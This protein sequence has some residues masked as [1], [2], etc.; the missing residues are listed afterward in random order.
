MSDM[1]KFKLDVRKFNNIDTEIQTLM[2]HI[3]PHNEKLKVLRQ[4]KK[5]LELQICEFM[6]S[7]DI[8]KCKLEDSSLIHQEK[9]ALVPLKQ[10]DIKDSFTNFFEKH[11]DDS[12]LKAKASEK[13]ELLFNYI[14]K[15]NREYSEK[16]T[17]TRQ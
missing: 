4:Q 7:N 6:T 5:D 10:K 3:K 8:D 16:N 13:S 17:L 15:E 12:F 14:Y 1:E 9:K 2:T 11:L